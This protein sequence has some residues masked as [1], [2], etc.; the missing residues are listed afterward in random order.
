MTRKIRIV[1][2]IGTGAAVVLLLAKQFL[3][4]RISDRALLREADRECRSIPQRSDSIVWDIFCQQAT[5]GYY[6][7]AFGTI[8]QVFNPGSDAQHAF[9]ALAR[10]RAEQGDMEEAKRLVRLYMTRDSRVEALKALAVIQVQRG[11]I[12]GATRTAYLVPDP[13]PVLEAVAIARAKTG[14]LRGARETIAPAGHSDNVLDAIAE[15]QFQAGDSDGALKTAQEMSSDAMVS[16]LVE[17]ADALRWRGKQ[18]SVRGLASRITNPKV[19]R[20]FLDVFASTAPENIEVFPPDICDQAMVLAERSDFA[21]A[22]SLMEKSKSD[23][24]SSVA[25][26]QYESDPAGAE[27]ALQHSSVRM[28]VCF[29]LAEFAK[30]AATHGKATEALRFIDTAQTRCGERDAYVL[31]AVRHVARQWTAR[32]KPSEVLK[33]AR[34]RPNPSQRALALLGIA[35]AMGDKRPRNS[36]TCCVVLTT[37]GTCC[38]VLPPPEVR[39]G[40][41]PRPEAK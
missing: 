30:A 9:V 3:V 25:V 19:A 35:E 24:Y 23:C 34:S 29:G 15:Y 22:Y 5:Q 18:A 37:S 16:R 33:W 10:M 27:R 1:F 39:V 12:P 11:D 4:Y 6:D 17:I 21:A 14:D 8:L 36:G 2:A 28:H 31:E 20:L 41:A 13:R 7:D 40:A 32:S 26:R 38:V